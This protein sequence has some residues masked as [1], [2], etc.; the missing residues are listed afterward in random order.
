MN[1]VV[2]IYTYKKKKIRFHY[3]R[4]EVYRITTT[5]TLILY[6]LPLPTAQKHGTVG[7]FGLR[8]LESIV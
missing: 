1:V 8:L 4:G 3:A 5:S 6:A 2:L 7:Q